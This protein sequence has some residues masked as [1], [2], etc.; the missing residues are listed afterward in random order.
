MASKERIAEKME[1][2]AMDGEHIGT[3]DHLDGEQSIKLAK[4]DPAAGGVHRWIPLSWVDT[5]D[6]KVCLSK[7]KQDVQAQWDTTLRQSQGA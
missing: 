7:S 2:V 5:V 4:T 3:V 6:D 1:V